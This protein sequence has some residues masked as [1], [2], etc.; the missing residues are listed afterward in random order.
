MLP[1]YSTDPPVAFAAHKIDY[2]V[3]GGYAVRF[4]ARL[5]F[6]KD[7]DLSVGPGGEP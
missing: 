1:R 2:L 7:M 3:V 6:A 5:R 4:H